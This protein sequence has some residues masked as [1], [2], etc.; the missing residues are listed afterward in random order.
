MIAAATT[1]YQRTRLPKPDPWHEQKK[2]INLHS[3]KQ[4]IFS[5]YQWFLNSKEKTFEIP[6]HLDAIVCSLISTYMSSLSVVN[7]FVAHQGRLNLT[8]LTENR[9]ILWHAGA[10]SSS[11]KQCRGISESSLFK[12]SRKQYREK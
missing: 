4:G 10:T 8:Q 1:A 7:T 12:L 2:L 5:P 6:H 9:Q 11:E 3:S